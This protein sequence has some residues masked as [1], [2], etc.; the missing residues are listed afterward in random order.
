[1]L[2]NKLEFN[3]NKTELRVIHSL[4]HP[5]PVFSLNRGYDII[6]PSN[7]ANNIGVSFDKNTTMIAQI[8]SVCKGAFYHLRNIGRIRK[9]LSLKSTEILVHAFISSQLDYCNSLFYGIIFIK[10]SK[11][12]S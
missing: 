7:M 3:E 12:Q 4:Y 6:T 9:F 1:M 2:L 11:I 5:S 10:T 8:N